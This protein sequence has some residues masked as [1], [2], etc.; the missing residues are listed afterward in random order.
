MPAH[1]NLGFHSDRRSATPNK[2]L[3]VYNP[4]Q[5]KGDVHRFS[6]YYSNVNVNNGAPFSFDPETDND[7]GPIGGD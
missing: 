3:T 1:P 2:K 5:V 6:L 7:G 4:A